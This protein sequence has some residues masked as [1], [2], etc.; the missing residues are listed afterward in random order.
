MKLFYVWKVEIEQFRFITEQ[1][2]WN[3]LEFGID[4]NG[5]YGN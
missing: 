1:N 3:N 5:I 4:E 2:N